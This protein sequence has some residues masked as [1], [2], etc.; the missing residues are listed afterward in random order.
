M[1]W[2]N[3]ETFTHTVCPQ[4]DIDIGSVFLAVWVLVVNIS[5]VGLKVRLRYSEVGPE[6]K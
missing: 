1:N 6:V 5:E 4:S 3:C 2:V